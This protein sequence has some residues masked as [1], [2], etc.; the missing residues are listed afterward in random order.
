MKRCAIFLWHTILVCAFFL[1]ICVFGEGFVAGTLVTA[2]S[3]VRIVAGQLRQGQALA[4][5]MH[6]SEV[7]PACVMGVSRTKMPASIKIHISGETIT[8]A[9][10]QR[11]LIEEQGEQIW[12]QA[13]W[14]HEGDWLVAA[15]GQTHQIQK[16]VVQ[17]KSCEFIDCSLDKQHVFFVGK[18][19][20]CAHN[21]IPYS[22]SGFAQASHSEGFCDFS[23]DGA[24][25]L[26]MF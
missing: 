1:N 10:D 24:G 3:G 22:V 9:V 20:I 16:T 5:R 23:F 26:G 12:R 4:S 13:V 18:K 17:K 7:S 15:D 21:S 14:L 11:L 8:L 6:N 2:S 19:K 25:V